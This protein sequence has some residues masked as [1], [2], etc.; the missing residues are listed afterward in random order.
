[1]FIE[2]AVS[3]LGRFVFSSVLQ[4]MESRRFLPRLWLEGVS[5]LSVA[6]LLG[7]IPS[8]IESKM[9]SM[10]RCTTKTE[11]VQLIKLWYS[12][13]CAIYLDFRNVKMWKKWSQH[14]WNI[15]HY[16]IIQSH[17][18]TVIVM[19]FLN[20]SDLSIDLLALCPFILETKLLW[21]QSLALSLAKNNVTPAPV[22]TDIP[23]AVTLES[24]GYLSV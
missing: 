14:Q 1:M 22:W 8:F 19:E 2:D 17:W 21:I 18:Y 16:L 20:K 7:N 10:I 24:L 9:L 5:D 13:N 11:N 6:S 23:Q 4:P 15:V 12:L 3:W